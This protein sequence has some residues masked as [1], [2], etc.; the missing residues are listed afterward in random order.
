MVNRQI[1][2]GRW[3]ELK[4]KIKERWGLL[5]DNELSQAEGDTDQLIGLI[6]Q[7]TG[8]SREH[9]EDELED[10]LATAASAAERVAENAREYVQRAS[11]V[12]REQYAHAAESVREGY[13]QAEDV[14]RRHPAE[15][16]GVAFG[17][18]LIT[19]VVVGMLVRRS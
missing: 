8:A 19:G 4:G 2:E 9:I 15:S 13:V 6:Q 11:S 12:A 16:V 3:N 7:K 14:V 10:L 1:L 5:T 18:G 17:V